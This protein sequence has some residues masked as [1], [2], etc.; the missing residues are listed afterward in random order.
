MPIH[1][2]QWLSICYLLIIF[3]NLPWFCTTNIDLQLANY[4][5]VAYSTGSNITGNFHSVTYNLTILLWFYT[6]K[7][8][9]DL[10]PLYT[11][12]VGGHGV[13]TVWF[14]F[15]FHNRQTWYLVFLWP[16][17]SSRQ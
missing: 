1:N 7:T 13:N 11:G 5:D 10:V 12:I 16:L 2:S 8:N 9:I 6:Y 14:R 15:D 3:Q 4:T 17:S